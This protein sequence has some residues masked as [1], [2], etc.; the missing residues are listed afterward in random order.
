LTTPL[1]SSRQVIPPT[2][3]NSQD[4]GTCL[5]KLFTLVRPQHWHMASV[6]T[7]H[8]TAA[9]QLGGRVSKVAYLG[10]CMAYSVETAVGDVLVISNNTANSHSPDAAV[11]LVA[12]DEHI[13]WVPDV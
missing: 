1:S 3:Y 11:T 10:H 13:R 12:S 8:V 5:K 4:I 7:P 9:V 2:I 6:N